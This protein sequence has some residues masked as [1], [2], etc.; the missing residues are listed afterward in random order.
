MISCYNDAMKVKFEDVDRFQFGFDV[1]CFTNVE[2]R[3]LKEQGGS[4][5]YKM[6]E[7]YFR[8]SRNGNFC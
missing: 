8:L 7:K 5:G 2:L 6:L 4:T 3:I 1:K